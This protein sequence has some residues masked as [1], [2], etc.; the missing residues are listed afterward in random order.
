MVKNCLYFDYVQEFYLA[1]QGFYLFY[2][3]Y[4]ILFHIEIDRQLLKYKI[5]VFYNNNFIC[6]HFCTPD[7]NSIFITFVQSMQ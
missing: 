6:L 1:K 7:N 4:S 3:G 5:T 2:L